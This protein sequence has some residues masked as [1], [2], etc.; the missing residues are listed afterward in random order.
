MTK[1]ACY[2]SKTKC[3]QQPVTVHTERKDEWRM[4]GMERK[5]VAK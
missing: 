2:M 1:A 3:T 4:H 5:Q